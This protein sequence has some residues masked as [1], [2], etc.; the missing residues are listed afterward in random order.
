[1]AL[2]LPENS[3]E[4]NFVSPSFLNWYNTTYNP[5]LAATNSPISDWLIK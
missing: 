1:M 3:F 4:N 2:I 5:S